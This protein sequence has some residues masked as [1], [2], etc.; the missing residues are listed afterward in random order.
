MS[1]KKYESGKDVAVGIF[2]Q[3]K[4]FDED[5]KTEEFVVEEEVIEKKIIS[6]D[7][8]G[9]H[10][11][12]DEINAS[13]GFGSSFTATK[14]DGPKKE[15]PKTDAELLAEKELEN[16]KIDV[17]A[18]I[19][20]SGGALKPSLIE[21]EEVVEEVLNEEEEETE[22][23]YSYDVTSQFYTQAIKPIDRNPKK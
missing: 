15:K 4:D 20:T 1:N 14:E 13:L 8:F 19:M 2:K 21:K 6:T 16:E 22:I 5:H 9:T 11:M 12:S 18:G 7:N 17:L 23:D 3:R 10:M